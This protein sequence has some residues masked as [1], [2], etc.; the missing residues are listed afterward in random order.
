[1]LP[2]FITV[3][4]LAT[5]FIR[6]TISVGFPARHSTSI[7]D[8]E[9]SEEESASKALNRSIECEENVKERE[10][11]AELGT[12]LASLRISLDFVWRNVNLI[13]EHIEQTYEGGNLLLLK[14]IS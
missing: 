13:I 9:S 7:Q 3:I 14:K 8:G 11:S 1:M 12:P 6:M 5:F 10:S 2:F 4:N